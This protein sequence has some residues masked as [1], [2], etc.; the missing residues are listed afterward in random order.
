VLKEKRVIEF[1]VLMVRGKK[2]GE[3][4]QVITDNTPFSFDGLY[5]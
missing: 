5:H 3:G 4:W 1:V 2:V